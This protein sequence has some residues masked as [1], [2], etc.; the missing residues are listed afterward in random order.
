MLASPNVQR[1]VLS[2]TL[3]SASGGQ[4]SVETQQCNGTCKHWPGWRNSQ[5]LQRSNALSDNCSGCTMAQ[6]YCLTRRSWRIRCMT[7]YVLDAAQP[8]L[9][10]AY[11]HIC[12]WHTDTLS[13]ANA[14]RR[15]GKLTILHRFAH[16]LSSAPHLLP[17]KAVL[18]L[19]V[20]L[21]T[22]VR[23]AAPASP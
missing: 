20:A 9:P 1:S 7:Q 12:A 14:S 5:L 22:V 13:N 16:L 15:Y 21:D 17:T 8:L 4:G 11:V 23:P 2:R 6:H 3:H 18:P 10:H 19:K